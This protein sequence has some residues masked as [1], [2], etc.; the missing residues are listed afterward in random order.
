MTSRV[1][2]ITTEYP[3]CGV[4]QGIGRVADMLA[5][6][7]THAGV[8]VLVLASTDSGRWRIEHGTASQLP[9]HDGP[10]A[11]RPWRSRAWIRH[12]CTAFAP[13]IIETSNW[14]GLDAGRGAWRTVVRL[15]TS[16]AQIPNELWRR[17][18]LR[19]LHL[20]WERRCVRHADRIIADSHAMAAV[21]QKLYA[22]GAD[23]VILHPHM[24]TI[25]PP[26]AGR[27]VLFVGRL[28]ARKGV[29]LLLA[30]WAASS[31]RRSG[32]TLHLVGRDPHGFGQQA[33][34][35]WGSTGVRC[36]GWLSEDALRAV[37][38]QCGIQVVPSRFESFG[39]VVLEA[40]AHGLAVIANN[41]GAL[42]EVVGT[43]GL[44]ADGTA[45][46]AEA[47]AVLATDSSRRQTLAMAGAERL[48]QHHDPAAFATATLAAYARAR[49]V[50][51]T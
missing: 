19:P 12:A 9:G 33:L 26:S 45:A 6:C 40:W 21:G 35:R 2:V 24:G 50:S 49:C 14:G 37:R 48:R 7:L 29:D 51:P 22:R 1:V 13:D 47:L 30:A 27:D 36:H 10:F 17:R 16:T 44:I 42:P 38:A 8:A 46:W 32:S 23:E 28:E 25:V 11:I 41:A 20:A 39:L 3:G 18:L 15:S 5:T 43:A 31:A 4:S 34:Q